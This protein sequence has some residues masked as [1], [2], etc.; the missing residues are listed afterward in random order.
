MTRISPMSE[1]ALLSGY[2]L[3]VT[4]L[5]IK[6]V[7]HPFRTG[8]NS[9]LTPRSSHISQTMNNAQGDI[10]ITVTQSH[11]TFRP[12]ASYRVMVPTLRIIISKPGM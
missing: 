9:S 2:T 1:Q 11:R 7:L 10:N 8:G 5:L 12:L 4:W 3:P 6:L